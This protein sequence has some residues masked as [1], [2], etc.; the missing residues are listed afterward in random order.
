M[1]KKQITKE[2][3]ARMIKRGFYCLGKRFNSMDKRFEGMKPRFDRI[4][5]RLDILEQG[6]KEII[7]IL[8]KGTYLSEK[9]GTQKFS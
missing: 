3:L 9:E 7:Q 6:Q 8:D 2:D 5:R 4:D 1:P